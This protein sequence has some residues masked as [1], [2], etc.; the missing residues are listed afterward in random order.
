M[1][2][3]Q[4]VYDEYGFDGGYIAI[5]LDQA[6]LAVGSHIEGKLY[7]RDKQGKPKYTLNGLLI[8]K[9]DLDAVPISRIK[10]GDKR[11]NP[12]PSVRK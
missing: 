10:R 4:H 3:R 6:I 8:E 2:I 5:A 1:D 9:K 11:I 7:E 12:K